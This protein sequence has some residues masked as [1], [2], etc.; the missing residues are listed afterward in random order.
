LECGVPGL[1]VVL[2]LGPGAFSDLSRSLYVTFS[3]R[4]VD[5]PPHF[6]EAVADRSVEIAGVFG[7]DRGSIVLRE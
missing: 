2:G 5:A 6:R 3:R 7:S 1:V 4:V